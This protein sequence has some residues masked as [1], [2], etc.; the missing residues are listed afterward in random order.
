MYLLASTSSSCAPVITVPIVT[1]RS[2]VSCRL[3]GREAADSARVRHHRQAHFGRQSSRRS[4]ETSRVG[5]RVQVVLMW[6]AKCCFS[7][8]AD[9][10]RARFSLSPLPPDVD[11]CRLMQV[12][13]T[14]AR[15]KR[16]MWILDAGPGRVAGAEFH[17]GA[18]NFA[19][20]SL[21]LS[22]HFQLVSVGM[23]SVQSNVLWVT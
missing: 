7:F 16:L 13:P 9:T 3:M 11:A 23:Q 5:S 14:L 6:G 4:F 15:E 12:A 22:K 19:T 17:D 1:R 21:Q 8:M 20:D 2:R 18:D 10:L